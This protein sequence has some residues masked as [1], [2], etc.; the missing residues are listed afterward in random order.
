MSKE[1]IK[2]TIC[3]LKD[4]KC[5]SETLIWII[6][7][8]SI[9]YYYYCYYF[10][11]SWHWFLT[12]IHSNFGSTFFALSSREFSL[13]PFMCYIYF[14]CLF[15]L[16]FI[17]FIYLFFNCFFVLLLT[18]MFS[19]QVLSLVLYLYFRIFL[20]LYCWIVRYRKN[21]GMNLKYRKKTHQKSVSLV[22]LKLECTLAYNHE[23]AWV[24]SICYKAKFFSQ[25]S[26]NFWYDSLWCYSLL[27]LTFFVLQRLEITFNDLVR[28]L[29]IYFG[30]LCL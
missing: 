20:I 7:C 23:K 21:W 8:F 4:T 13:D 1:I 5:F 19:P 3:Y 10:I 17:L 11:A 24:L 14:K 25:S 27:D 22:Q 9:G 30:H 26:L 2:P 29:F 6:F 28:Y 12:Y 15:C 18:F 16:I